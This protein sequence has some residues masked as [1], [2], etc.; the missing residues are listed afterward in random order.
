MLQK[1]G[2]L[3]SRLYITWYGFV[4]SHRIRQYTGAQPDSFIALLTG[5][6]A[7]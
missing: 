4:A 3:V 6:P 2:D 1:F 7:V 5:L